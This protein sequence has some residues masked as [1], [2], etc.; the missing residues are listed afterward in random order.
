M[1]AEEDR[2]AVAE[3]LG[4]EPRGE[5]TVAHRCPCGRPDVVRTNPRLPDGTPFPTLYYLTCPRATAACSTLESQ[6]VMRE[7][8]QRLATAL[9][10]IRQGRQRETAFLF[11]D[12]DRFKTVNDSCG[13]LVGDEMLRRLA[14]LIQAQLRRRDLLARLG[15]DEFGVLLDG[16]PLPESLPLAEK[17]RTAVDTMRFSWQEKEF[18]VGVS[19]GLVALTA[20]TTD[21]SSLLRDADAACYRAKAEGRN[22]IEIHGSEGPDAAP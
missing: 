17:V 22:R 20:D 7:M 5:M 11:M 15:G 3:Q 14:E 13:H 4:R 18:R 12:L 19:I 8:E 1:L 9:E 21:I 2:A 6:G 10:A 16:C